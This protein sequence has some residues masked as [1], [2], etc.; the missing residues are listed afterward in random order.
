M[1]V[2]GLQNWECVLSGAV[3]ASPQTASAKADFPVVEVSHPQSASQLG[4][5]GRYCLMYPRP[6]IYL[7][8]MEEVVPDSR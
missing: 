4:D 7:M 1:Y 3:L 5:Y 6:D 8:V 2:G